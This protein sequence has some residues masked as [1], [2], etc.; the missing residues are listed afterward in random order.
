MAARRRM[1]GAFDTMTFRRKLLLSSTLTVVVSV[2][3]VAG[4]VTAAIRRSVESNEEARTQA[5]WTQF[6]H[7]FDRQG[8]EVARKADAIAVSEPFSNM[9]AHLSRST[10]D[11]NSYFDLARSLA[12]TYQIDFLELVDGRGMIISSAQ[13]PANFG[14]PEPALTDPNTIPPA[15]P[16]L[17]QETL[18][19]GVA[20]GLFAT[21]ALRVDGK[22]FYVLAGRGLD[23]QFLHSLDL[24]SGMR[25]LLYENR[26]PLSGDSLMESGT[27][28]SAGM[29]NR[30]FPII[31]AVQ[32]TR[33][34]TTATISWSSDAGDDE[35]FHAFP[36]QSTGV[37]PDLL[38]IFLVGT[39]QRSFIDMERR[40]RAIAFLVGGGGM[41]LAT[42]FGI[43]TAERVT[44]PVQQLAQAARRVAEGNWSARVEVKG[45]DELAQ[46]ADSFN[47][48]TT[49]LERQREQLVQ[50]ER[51]AAW[52]ELARRLAHE[53]NNPLFPL[54]LTVENLVRAR[55]AAPEQFDEMFPECTSALLAE[56]AN[57]KSII[58]RFSDF[59]R[60]P[61]PQLQSVQLNQAIQS[62]R[63]LLL[64]QMNAPGHTAIQCV[65]ELDS[66]LQPILADPD[67]L[68]RVLSNLILN[69]IDAMPDGGRLTLRT[70][71]AGDHAII[72]VSDTGCG[73]T[74]EECERI[75]TPYY[76]SK[77]HG[78]G[79]GLAIVQSV[80]SDHGGTISVTSD[81][82]AGTT[83]IISLPRPPGSKLDSKNCGKSPATT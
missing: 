57:L 46:M 43:W 40:I 39:S 76:T 83:F 62:V 37:N 61:Q 81:S 50:T 51:V 21:R 69:A 79:L 14:Y 16:F 74:R 52:R 5:L 34:E 60:M 10:S 80:V 54:Q 32:Q 26:G 77:Q 56:I 4:L 2:G 58:S 47:R 7:A 22:L 6:R 19:T 64:A 12:D 78:T 17:K 75:F 23:A 30:F 24:P 36:L 41:L 67:L 44:R 71:D 9:A 38:G 59:S 66:S 72:E 3:A 70:R 68:H 35:A 82:N 18:T 73:L 15:Q 8:Q 42:L 31:R 13:S 29:V 28:T 49:D 53:L 45:N 63:H 25:A 33:Q 55:T 27:R 11:T 48:M 1:A 65:M 20:L